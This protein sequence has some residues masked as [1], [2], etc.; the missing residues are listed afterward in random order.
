MN[1]DAGICEWID[2]NRPPA[3]T[4]DLTTR[5]TGTCSPLRYQYLVD[6]LTRLSITSVRKSPNMISTTGRRPGDRRT[7][8][9]A[10]E[11]ELRDRRVEDALRPVLL[12]QPG[13]D[14]ED[15]TRER[16]VLAEEDDAVVGGQ[17]SSSASRTA[18]R[19]SI[20]A[21]NA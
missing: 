6:W 16:N 8:R 17:P 9:R 4:T 1:H 20:V 12:V 5:G 15:T 19:K 2:P 7:E 11:R 10:R 14:G 21:V 13:R 3:P 18:V